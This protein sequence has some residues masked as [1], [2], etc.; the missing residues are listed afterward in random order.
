MRKIDDL[1]SKPI[2]DQLQ[3]PHSDFLN[4]KELKEIYNNSNIVYFKNKEVIIRQG[5]PVSH[6]MYVK[7][8]YVKIF[9]EGRNSNYI[10]LKIEQEGHYLGM[11]SVFGN[12]VHKY[13]VSSIN[14]SEIG[15]IDINV[16][17]NIILQNGKFAYQIINSLS[18]YG[19]FIFD[20]LMSQSH[21]QLPGR[22]ADVLLYFSEEIYHS[23]KFTFPFTRKELA[24]LAGTTKESFI[25]TLTEFKN[26]KIIKLDGSDVEIV[27]IEN[28][29]MLSRLG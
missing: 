26:D 12:D 9:K 20:R 5:T 23:Q 25:R 21:K 3:L 6:I 29:K 1:L 8:G 18:N 22:I 17:K 16:F 13:S 28:V 7:S 24:E 14:H 27:S 4:E 10:I 11:L 15:F 2:K 19:L